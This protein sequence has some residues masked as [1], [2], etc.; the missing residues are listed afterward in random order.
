MEMN[1]MT[2]AKKID[3]AQIML[4]WLLKQYT[5]SQTFA[6]PVL[7]PIAKKYGQVPRSS[8]N[9][10]LRKLI[11]AACVERTDD[12]IENARGGSDM[13]L[14]KITGKT[15]IDPVKNK[16]AAHYADIENKMECMTECAL[17]LHYA[18]NRIAR[19]AHAFV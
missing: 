11:A 5:P 14:Y 16:T 9:N 8:A 3:L 2:T 15:Q 7:Y 17:T 19:H 12:V 6:A 10:M 18:L 13:P 4:T 1:K